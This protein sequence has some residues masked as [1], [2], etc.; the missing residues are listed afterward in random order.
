M[1]QGRQRAANRNVVK[2]VMDSRNF[3]LYFSRALIPDSP[4]GHV[5]ETGKTPYY[6]H[7]GL[8]AYRPEALIDFVE[9]GPS[10]LE[11][12]E[13]LEQLRALELGMR[14]KVIEV[15]DAATGIDTE[16]QLEEA[17]ALFLDARDERR[18]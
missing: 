8:Y 13:S 11:Q 10:Q 9:S 14:I 6:K 3:A 18:E 4:L 16:D 17:R 5:D 1:V 12:H 2:C 7:I 15:G